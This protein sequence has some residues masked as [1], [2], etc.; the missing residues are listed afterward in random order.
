MNSYNI[1]DYVRLIIL[2][3]CSIICL[4]GFKELPT[5][6]TREARPKSL[7][8]CLSGNKIIINM[9]NKFKITRKEF[10]KVEDPDKSG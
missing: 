4:N 2:N 8:L 3:L 10:K 6:L 5:R 7:F 1:N 9:S